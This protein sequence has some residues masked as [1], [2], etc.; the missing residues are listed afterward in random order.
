MASAFAPAPAPAKPASL[1]QPLVGL[2]VLVVTLEG[3]TVVGTLK[4]YDSVG[5]VVLSDAH[6]RLFSPDRGMEREPLGLYLIRGDAL[7]VCGSVG[8]GAARGAVPS[9]GKCRAWRSTWWSVRTHAVLFLT[10]DTPGR[11]AFASLAPS[12]PAPLTND[13]LPP[14]PGA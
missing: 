4:G 2:V 6:E 13:T 1:L 11:V 3:R 5:N 8:V 9:G 12:W 14:S 10:R 7:C